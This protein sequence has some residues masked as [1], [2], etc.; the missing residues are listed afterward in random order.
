LANEVVKELIFALP[1][2]T[3]ESR[4]LDVG[5][6]SGRAAELA[7]AAYPEADYTL[8]DVD[9]ERGSMALRRLQASEGGE[10]TRHRFVKCPLEPGSRLDLLA[11]A[12]TRGGNGKG[13]AFDCII[14]LQSIRHIVAPPAHYAQKHQLPRLTETSITPAERRELIRRRYS[15][16]C[17]S[18]HD[19]LVPGGHLLLGDHV[20]NDHPG[21]F[22]HCELMRD[23]GFE[24]VDVAWVKEGWFVVGGRAKKKI[25]GDVVIE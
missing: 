18:L 16:M 13:N 25:D 19:A 20:T 17:S 2:L 5:C 10:S 6:G 15:A 4:V 9:E 23:A 14:A 7:I 8:V 3:R 24:D 12:Q 22:E 21:V 11:P 1:P